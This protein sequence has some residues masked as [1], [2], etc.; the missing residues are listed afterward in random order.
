MASFSKGGYDL[1][2]CAQ[3]TPGDL[4][5]G[6]ASVSGEEASVVV[7]EVW[8]PGTPHELVRD[9]EVVLRWV[10]G[11][12]K[13]ADIPCP[14]AETADPMPEGPIP[15]TPEGAVTGFY[16][17][18]LWYAREVGNPL[19]TGAYRSSEYLTPDL[20]QKMDKTI[21]SFDRSGYDPFLCAQDLPESFTLDEAVVSGDEASLV[22]HTS[23]ADHAFG[24]ELEQVN[25]RWAVSDVVCVAS[26]KRRE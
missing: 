14:G 11:R 25:G 23:F 1:F 18:Y 3:D 15:M 12:W 19:V 24:V 2:L 5:T 20:V 13:I 10:D 8:N 4:S 21:A 26:G 6:K 9:V 17:W 22:V 16:S 7:Q